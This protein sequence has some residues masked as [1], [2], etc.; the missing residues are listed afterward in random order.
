MKWK[1][2][3]ERLHERVLRLQMG[4]MQLDFDDDG[5]LLRKRQIFE[6]E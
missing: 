3:S 4:K 6:I 2:C 5:Y 1:N